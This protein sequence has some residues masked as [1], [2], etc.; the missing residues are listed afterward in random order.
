MQDLPRAGRVHAGATSPPP[1][2]PKSTRTRHPESPGSQRITRT[3]EAPGTAARRPAAG[4]RP[5]CTPPPRTASRGR[6]GRLRACTRST[7]RRR[8]APS[9]RCAPGAS[10]PG[11]RR[12]TRATSPS[13]KSHDG[14][15]AALDRR[16]D[17]VAGRLGTRERRVAASTVHLGLSPRLW[18]A[19]LGSAAL[20][21]PG[22]PTS[23]PGAVGWNPERTAPDDLW[24]PAGPDGT[25]TDDG[26]TGGTETDGERTDGGRTDVGGPGG[27]GACAHGLRAAVVTGHLAP[28][29]DAVPCCL[30]P[31]GGAA[32]GQR[33]LRAGREPSAYWT[34]GAGST[35]APRRRNAPRRLDPGAAPRRPRWTPPAPPS[36]RRQRT[37]RRTSGGGPAACTTGCRAAGCAGTASSRRDPAPD[38]LGPRGPALDG[39]P[40]RGRGRATAPSRGPGPPRA[41]N[42]VAPAPSP[43]HYQG[44]TTAG[45]GHPGD[46]T[47]RLPRRTRLRAPGRRGRPPARPRAIRPTVADLF[48]E[49]GVW[50][51]AHGNPPR[52]GTRRRCAATSAPGPRTGSRA[53]SART[54]SSRSPPQT[55]AEATT[56]FATYRVDGYTGGMLPP[57]PPANMGHYED[58]FRR[59]DGAWLLATRSLCTSPFGGPTERLPGSER[60]RSAEERR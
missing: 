9:S 41:E 52:R 7:T 54:S 47:E 26:R 13:R 15:T 60:N 20:T 8:S 39:R 36:R 50:E 46:M 12:A 18:S 1:K 6:C 2:I 38:R 34:A 48:T 56:Y 49:D 30:P 21:G 11:V 28:L 4:A 42:P 16:I 33:G 43:R 25:E 22:S 23:R 24:L 57:R 53:A 10:R 17:V 32:V 59:V 19:A 55:T 51:W 44:T 35:T 58:T 3:V 37:G 31:P 5:P 14:S 29:H 45:T 27:P 40:P